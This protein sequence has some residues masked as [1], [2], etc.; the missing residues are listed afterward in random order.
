MRYDT[1]FGKAVGWAVFILQLL[2]EQAPAAWGCTLPGRGM[3]QGTHFAALQVP[4]SSFLC[5]LHQSFLVVGAKC[6]GLGQRTWCEVGLF[7]YGQ[8][9]HAEPWER[10]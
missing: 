4:N 5:P 1:L 7:P 3:P 9:S 10:L 8:N 2:L 6:L